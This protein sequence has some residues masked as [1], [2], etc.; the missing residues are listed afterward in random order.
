M[1]VNQSLLVPFIVC[2]M[3]WDNVFGENCGV[4]QHLL[5]LGSSED[6]DS[7]NFLRCI[8]RHFSG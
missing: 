4:I 7:G 1:E 8:V 3:V 5:F 6:A 2:N